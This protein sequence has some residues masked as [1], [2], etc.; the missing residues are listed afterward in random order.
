MKDIK[1]IFKGNKSP[2]GKNTN[3]EY[4]MGEAKVKQLEKDGRFDME[5]V[6]PKAPKSKKKSKKEDKKEKNDE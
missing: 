5:I 4:M 3:V 2:S 1:V 6:K